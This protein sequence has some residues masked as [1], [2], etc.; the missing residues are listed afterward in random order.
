M[1]ITLL[2]HT[3][4]PRCSGSGAAGVGRLAGAWPLPLT[5]TSRTLAHPP[6]AHALRAHAQTVTM[7][8]TLAT[9]R[10]VL[11]EDE[12]YCQWLAAQVDMWCAIALFVGYNV[13]CVLIYVLQSGYIDLLVG[14]DGPPPPE[15]Q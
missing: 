12:S 4:T 13:A 6:A 15:W 2:G 11:A 5:S 9:M 8:P 7:A 1:G 3:V 10:D 14:W